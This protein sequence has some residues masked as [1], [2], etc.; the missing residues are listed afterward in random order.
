M[1]KVSFRF[2]YDRE[3]HPNWDNEQS[4]WWFSVLD[5]VAVLTDQDEYTKTRNY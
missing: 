3:V 2:F 5:I 4:K 1:N